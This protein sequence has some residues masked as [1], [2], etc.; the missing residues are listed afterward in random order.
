MRSVG[1]GPH[2]GGGKRDANATKRNGVAHNAASTRKGDGRVQ[3]M[4]G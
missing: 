4:S 2:I 3:V 1:R